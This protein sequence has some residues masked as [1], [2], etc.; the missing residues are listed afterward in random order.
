M[1]IDVKAMRASWL[2]AVAAG[3]HGE[4][5]RHFVPDMLDEIEQLKEQIEGTFVTCTR[6]VKQ[7]DDFRAAIEKH[8]SATGHDLCW[9][10]DIELWGV[11]KDG[12][13]LDHTPPPWPEF[14]TKCALYRASRDCSSKK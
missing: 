11:L 14:M 5:A 7:R 10:N 12:V 8:R 13:A 9:E 3:Q 2:E 4:F 6:L 1:G